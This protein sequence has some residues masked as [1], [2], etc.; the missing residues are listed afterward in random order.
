MHGTGFALTGPPAASG[1][2]QQAW[3]AAESLVV[4]T[5]REGVMKSHLSTTASS[6][7]L[8]L[9]GWSAGS[10][11]ALAATAVDPGVRAAS[12]TDT[13]GNPIPGLTTDQTTL[14]FNGQATFKEQELIANGLGPRF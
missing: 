11:A 4:G 8:I 13:F 9:L 2:M 1:R 7:A 10:A 6:V 3:T 14:F 5:T 12:A